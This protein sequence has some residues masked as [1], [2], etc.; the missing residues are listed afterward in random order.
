MTAR[1]D[2]FRMSLSRLAEE[3]KRV[4]TVSSNDEQMVDDVANEKSDLNLTQEY[5]QMNKISF[6]W[7]LMSPTPLAARV[8][9]K[10]RRYT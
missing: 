4:S 8:L 10:W 2:L 5:L 6:S 3:N 7:Y 9:S 1:I